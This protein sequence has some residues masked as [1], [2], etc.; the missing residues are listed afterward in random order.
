MYLSRSISGWSFDCEIP[1]SASPVSSNNVPSN[2]KGQEIR[3]VTHPHIIRR[4][5]LARHEQ[6]DLEV[7][8]EVVRSRSPASE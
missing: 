5:I 6:G 2:T 8:I 1:R 4:S 7:P 3:I